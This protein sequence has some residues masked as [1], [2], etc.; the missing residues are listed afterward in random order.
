MSLKH[1]APN[2]VG[3]PLIIV[4]IQSEPKRNICSKFKG[5]KAVSLGCDWLLSKI[6][7]HFFKSV[8]VNK[9]PKTFKWIAHLAIKQ[10]VRVK[11][12][13]RALPGA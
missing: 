10:A 7:N 5:K 13:I 11:W 3:I 4:R 1:L 12:E 2:F 8:K 9:S 6:L